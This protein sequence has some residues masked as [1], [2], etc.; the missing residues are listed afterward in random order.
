ME[1]WPRPRTEEDLEKLRIK[2]RKLFRDKAM[3]QALVS[4]MGSVS[5]SD[6]LGKVFDALQERDVSR[7][8][9]FV[10]LLQVG[11]IVIH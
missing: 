11:R 8:L 1:R 10:L 3:P 9:V 6:A 4:I 7:G 5:S 2:A